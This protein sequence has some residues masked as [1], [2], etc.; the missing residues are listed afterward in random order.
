MKLH[1]IFL[2]AAIAIATAFTSCSSDDSFEPGKPAGSNNV[3]FADG[4]DIIIEG[5]TTSFDVTLKR[6][7]TSSALDVPVE[8]V[9]AGVFTL[10]NT[11]ASFAAGDSLATITVAVPADMAK[12]TACPLELR[13][14]EEYTNPYSNQSTYSTYLAYVTM[15]DYEVK[16]PHAAFTDYFLYEEAW[17]VDIQYSPSQDLY[18]IKDLFVEGTH[19][20]FKWNTDTNVITVTNS[21]GTAVRYWDTGYYYDYYGE[22]I[23]CYVNQATFYYDPETKKIHLPFYWY[24][25]QLGGG[26]GIIE[27]DITIY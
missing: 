27:D 21:A 4:S 9:N 23:V 7:N 1:K 11:T 18:R 8:V 22:D 2:F 13:I 17:E 24:L 16:Y 19:L 6:T 12:N 3:T 10:T 14:P 20:Y 5:S 26:W 25:L 15:E